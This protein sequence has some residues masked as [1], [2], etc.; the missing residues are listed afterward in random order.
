MNR[1][2]ITLLICM[3]CFSSCQCGHTKRKSDP[4]AKYSCRL[5]A[6]TCVLSPT[7]RCQR[8]YS[9]ILDSH[10]ACISRTR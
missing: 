3:L 1:Y 5:G 9:S 10:A 8:I 6:N 2:T 7:C 4:C